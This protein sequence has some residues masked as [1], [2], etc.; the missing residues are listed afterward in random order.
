MGGRG[1]RDWVICRWPLVGAA[2]PAVAT[3]ACGSKAPA[4]IFVDW[5]VIVL[6][7]FVDRLPGF[8]ERS[9]CVAAVGPFASR[10]GRGSGGGANGD[11]TTG[12]L[13]VLG[14]PDDRDGVHPGA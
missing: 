8:G 14:P 2:R 3:Y 9:R 12:G 10:G 4:G 7:T 6:A 1:D 11:R 13:P 5:F